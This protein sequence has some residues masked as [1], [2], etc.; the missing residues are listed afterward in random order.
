MIKVKNKNRIMRIY[1]QYKGDKKELVLFS[2]TQ[3]GLSYL[4]DS[5]KYIKSIKDMLM[6]IDE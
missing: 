2:K 5:K 6:S 4:V 3:H 1:E